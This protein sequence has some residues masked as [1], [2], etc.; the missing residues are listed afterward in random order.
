MSTISSNLADAKRNAEAMVKGLDESDLS[1]ISIDNKEENKGLIQTHS[2]C[3]G[4]EK[5]DLTKAGGRISPPPGIHRILLKI[6]NIIGGR[7]SSPLRTNIMPTETIDEVGEYDTTAN[8]STINMQKIEPMIPEK[9]TNIQSQFVVINNYNNYA[10]PGPAFPPNIMPPG[11]PPHMSDPRY[12]FY[13]PMPTPGHPYNPYYYPY[14]NYPAPTPVP[15]QYFP[16]RPREQKDP[17]KTQEEDLDKLLEKIEVAARDQASCRLLQRKLEEK[18]TEFTQ[19]IFSRLITDIAS[20]MNDPFGNYLCQK[21]FEQCDST[22]MSQVIDHISADVVS[23]ATDLHGTRAIQK[24][25]EKAVTD[26]DLLIKATQLLKGH[27]AKLVMDN[28][29][30]HVVQQCLQNIKAPHNQFIY[31]EVAENCLAIATHKHGCC[32]LQKCID[33]SNES[34]KVFL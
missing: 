16:Y 8:S 2:T 9:T 25:I 5:S 3:E 21:V 6:F 34:Q 29:G 1:Q 20:Y 19:K 31:D 17:E 33:F 11:M 14:P 27:I 12:G 24:V 28:N 26:S 15:N 18:S 4:E 13:P 32:V 30:N 10:Y 23:I 22:Q 7:R